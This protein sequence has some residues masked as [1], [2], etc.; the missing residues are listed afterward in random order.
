MKMKL[1]KKS[2]NARLKDS[3]PR[4]SS[5]IRPILATT[6]LSDESLAG[7]RYARR[8]LKEKNEEETTIDALRASRTRGRHIC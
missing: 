3:G 7:V 1:S 6:D 5:K 2:G 4:A 8:T